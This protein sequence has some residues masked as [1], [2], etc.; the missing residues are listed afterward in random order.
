MK[1]KYFK[2]LLLIVSLLIVVNVSGQSIK[3]VRINEI[4]VNNTNGLMDE[5]GQYG[6]W[7][8]LYNTGYGKVNIG[9]CILK[10]NGKI[11]RIPQGDPATVMDT[12][13]YTVFYAG[14]ISER[15]T[16]YTNFTLE[17]TNF[18]EFYDVDGDLIDRFEFNPVEMKE[19]IS[20]GWVDSH[21]GK[22]ILAHLPA[23]TPRASN[24]TEEKVTRAEV[25]RQADPIGLVLTLTSIFVVAVALIVLFLIFKY[26]GKFHVKNAQKKKKQQNQ[27]AKVAAG[28]EKGSV[29]TNEE[30]A[31]ISI[32]LYKYSQDL[33]DI[34]TTVLTINRAA[35]VYSPWSSKIHSLTQTPNRK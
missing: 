17:N 18:I 6:G 35:K 19:N 13:G 16:F 25:F 1:K 9:G 29:L 26:M 24:N 4:Q 22:E 2:Y 7:L 34:E 21:D 8:E 23:I 32:A 33:H 12:R 28:K 10:V 3:S 27:P 15:G 5:Y 31:A 14:G 20:Y 11:Y 30:L